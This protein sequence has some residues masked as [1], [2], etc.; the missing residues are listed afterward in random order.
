MDM[1]QAYAPGGTAQV[2]PV[3]VGQPVPVLPSLNVMLGPVGAA[4]VKDLSKPVLTPGK[5]NDSLVRF[6]IYLDRLDAGQ[7]TL[8]DDVKVSTLETSLPHGGQAEVQRRREMSLKGTEPPSCIK[9]CGT[10]WSDS[11]VRMCSSPLWK[12]F[13]S[14]SQKV[15]AGCLL[16]HGELT[17]VS[18]NSGWVGWRN[19]KATKLPTGC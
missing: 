18:S 1:S 13:G 19:P 2:R 17:L 4:M 7:G 11:M 10:G 8:P 3:T 15:K 9:I 12:S 6:S 5:G 14:S 16:R